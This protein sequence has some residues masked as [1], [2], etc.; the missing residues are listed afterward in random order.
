MIGTIHFTAR[1]NMI[2]ISD[3][4]LAML[5]EMWPEWKDHMTVVRS[6]VKHIVSADEVVT[7]PVNIL[8]VVVERLKHKLISDLV[9][10]F[11]PEIIREDR[12][13]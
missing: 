11:E 3:D 7:Q 12:P 6:E 5:Q 9:E 10:R 1:V 4:G 8:P 2:G 13:W